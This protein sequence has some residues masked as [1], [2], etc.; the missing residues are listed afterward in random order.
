MGIV[1]LPGWRLRSQVSDRAALRQGAASSRARVRL[2]R[3]DA[4]PVRLGWC[5]RCAAPIE[6]GAVTR[7][8]S[9]YCSVVCS[10]ER[11]GRPA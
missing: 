5:D 2:V 11:P 7:G 10:L 8:S 3:A 9:V 6:G 1:E 4:A